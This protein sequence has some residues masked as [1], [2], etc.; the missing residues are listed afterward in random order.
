MNFLKQYF[1]LFESFIISWLYDF[2]NLILLQIILDSIKPQN[3]QTHDL[4]VTVWYLSGRGVI[5]LLLFTHKFSG[6]VNTSILV[7]FVDVSTVRCISS[8]FLSHC[9]LQGI[10]WEW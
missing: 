7:L 9:K 1:N 6:L 2:D 3:W 8:S 5:S 10:D 4:I